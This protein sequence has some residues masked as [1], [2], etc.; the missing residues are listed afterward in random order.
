MP[1]GRRI[2]ING[3]VRGGLMVCAGAHADIRG[4]VHGS[5]HDEGGTYRILGQVG[6]VRASRGHRYV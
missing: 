6:S 1:S 3:E 2:E 4:V 5:L